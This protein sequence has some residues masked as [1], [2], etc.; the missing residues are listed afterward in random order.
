MPRSVW[1][2]RNQS[3]TTLAACRAVRAKM[4]GLRRLT[5][6]TWWLVLCAITVSSTPGCKK[7]IDLHVHNRY[8]FPVVV[9]DVAVSRRPYHAGVIQAGTQGLLSVARPF[10][11]TYHLEIRKLDGSVVADIVRPRDV[12]DRSL[13]NNTWELSVGPAPDRSAPG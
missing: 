12:I 8:P 1:R 5:K 11:S 7:V 13:V 9:V 3:A 10:S 2:A 4:N 6:A